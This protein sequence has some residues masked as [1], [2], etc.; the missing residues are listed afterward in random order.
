MGFHINTGHEDPNFT[1]LVA[2]GVQGRDLGY[3]TICWR[4]RRFAL[5]VPITPLSRDRNPE[6][7]GRHWRDRLW[8]DAYR[9]LEDAVRS[10]Q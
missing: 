8:N 10:S 7:A 2:R 6:Y 1:V 4:S 3:I 9:E 5:G